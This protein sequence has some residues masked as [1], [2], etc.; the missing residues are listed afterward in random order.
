MECGGKLK[1]RKIAT[2][3]APIRKTI[4]LEGS[5]KELE[6]TSIRCRL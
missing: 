6:G 3:N 4:A 1:F 2:A 5:A